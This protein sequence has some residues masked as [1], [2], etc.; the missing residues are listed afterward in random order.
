V[1]ANGKPVTDPVHY[2]MRDLDNISIGYG[3]LGSFPHKPDKT[4]LKAV[5]GEGKQAA[6]S[7]ARGGKGTK[8]CVAGKTP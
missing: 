3:A 4:A 7:G 1:F 5:T 8:S 6:C 2:V